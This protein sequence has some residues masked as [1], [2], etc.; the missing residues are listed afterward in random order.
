MVSCCP[1]LEINEFYSHFVGNTMPNTQRDYSLHQREYPK[2]L[3]QLERLVK[4]VQRHD[5]NIA[6]IVLFGST[7]RLEPGPESDADV[8]LL[9]HDEAAYFTG[10]RGH[11]PG[12]VAGSALLTLAY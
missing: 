2:L 1:T 8:L 7:A 11:A 5:A 6:M 3:W 9:L 10:E 4:L 12:S